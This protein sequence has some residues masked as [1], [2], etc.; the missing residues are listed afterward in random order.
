MFWKSSKFETAENAIFSHIA[1]PPSSFF[2]FT[3]HPH[4]VCAPRSAAVFTRIQCHTSC[5]YTWGFCSRIGSYIWWGFPGAWDRLV[6]RGT[7]LPSHSCH[8]HYA[9]RLTESLA[10]LGP[11]FLEVIGEVSQ[12][13]TV[14]S[15]R[16]VQWILWVKGVH[17]SLNLETIHLSTSAI[18]TKMMV[19]KMIEFLIFTL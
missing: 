12:I 8:P 9:G 2:V 11:C 19:R 1:E 18:E 3:S 7:N 5:T 4:H 16:C 17:R 10:W 15:M 14:I 6:C 13:R